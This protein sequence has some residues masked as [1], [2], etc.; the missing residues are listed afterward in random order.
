MILENIKVKNFGVFR[1]EHV[2]DLTPDLID[3][4]IILFGGLNGSGKTTLFEG[5]KLCLYGQLSSK[6]LRT[7]SDYHE[8][9]KKKILPLGKKEK[10]TYHGAIELRIQF[11]D[12]GLIN[13]YSIRRSWKEKW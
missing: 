7:K 10:R 5:I 4:P 3:K 13:L 6:N 2:F 11:N 8:Y 1:G 9:L 12:F